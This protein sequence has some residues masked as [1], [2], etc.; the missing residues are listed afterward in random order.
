M[1]LRWSKNIAGIRDFAKL[2]FSFVDTGYFP[3]NY[4]T[5]LEKRNLL[6]DYDSIDRNQFPTNHH[7]GDDMKSK[8]FCK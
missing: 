2:R 6:M 1:E 8:Y 4:Q 5:F 3:A 7:L